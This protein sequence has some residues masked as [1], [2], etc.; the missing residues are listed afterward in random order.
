MQ[1]ARANDNLPALLL[2][3]RK[4]IPTWFFALVVVRKGDQYLVVKERRHGQRWYLPA[5]RVEPG[6]SIVGAAVR[7]TREESGIP[8]TVEGILRIEHEPRPDGTA[9]VRVFFL[10][11]PLDDTPPKTV[12]DEDSLGAAW[13][14]LDQLATLPLRDEEVRVVVHAVARGAP[15]YPLTL[16]VTERY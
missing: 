10:A 8:V 12:P 3:A 16:L 5:G 1:G 15:A 2:V 4:P 9:R 11:R 7:E 13:M 6:E 14:T